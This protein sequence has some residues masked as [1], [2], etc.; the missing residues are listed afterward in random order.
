MRVAFFLILSLLFLH[1]C[2]HTTGPD[3][4]P[5]TTSVEGYIYDVFDSRTMPVSNATMN[6]NG[7]TYTSNE[8]G[9]FMLN[10]IPTGEH[11]VTFSSQYHHNT[12][13]VLLFEYNKNSPDFFEIELASI[14]LDLLPLEIGN[15]WVYQIE[16]SN[17]LR[18]LSCLENCNSSQFE[19]GT[20]SVEV[21]ELEENGSSFIYTMQETIEGY[22]VNEQN[23]T[24]FFNEQGS[25]IITEDKETSSIET[26]LTNAASFNLFHY[27]PGPLF[28]GY[29]I[30]Q[31]TKS[32][33]GH[34]SSLRYI[35]YSRIENEQS[36]LLDS[37]Y[38]LA[39]DTGTV[40]FNFEYSGNNGSGY[41]K[42]ELISFEDTN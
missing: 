11:E 33:W 30:I 40:Y 21:V 6:I 36:I 37:P 42:K 34:Y 18:K 28:D 5:N 41:N 29:I 22:Y 16:S 19:L 12:D 27:L 25:Y 35:P 14:Q 17:T 38:S 23:D 13:T 31:E 8:D 10:D 1:A 3:P 2:Q 9:E 4:E 39:I 15:K 7:T 20:E 26:D 24:T 32:E